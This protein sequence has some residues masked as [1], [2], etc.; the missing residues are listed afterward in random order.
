MHTH[1]F[2][3]F[4]PKGESPEVRMA[5]PMATR[6]PDPSALAAYWAEYED[7]C[8]QIS[9]VN[10]ED[11]NNYE[12]TLAPSSLALAASLEL[13]KGQDDG[14]DDDVSDIVRYC[15]QGLI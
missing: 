1:I 14:C 3:N 9:S 15:R 12:G 11:D 4:T 2:Q 6:A 13:E 10:D 7:L 5:L 8:R